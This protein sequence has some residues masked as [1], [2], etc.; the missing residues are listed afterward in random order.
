[1]REAHCALVRR[2]GLPVDASA[3]LQFHAHVEQALEE[4]KPR[5]KNAT[6][7]CDGVVVAG[8]RFDE[9]VCVFRLYARDV[10]RVLLG[11]EVGEKE[12]VALAVRSAVLGGCDAIFPHVLFSS[13]ELEM[14]DA[15]DLLRSSWPDFL[16]AAC[17]L[18]LAGGTPAAASFLEAGGDDAIAR[19][20]SVE[21]DGRTALEI[22]LYSLQFG[23]FFHRG[24]I[25]SKHAAALLG[26]WED[27]RV[28]PPGGQ[29]AARRAENVLARSASLLDAEEWKALCRR[30]ALAH[31]ARVCPA[32]ASQEDRAQSA[33]FWVEFHNSAASVLG[34]G[35][36]AAAKRRRKL[37]LFTWFF[38]GGTLYAGARM[39]L[40][41]EEED[42]LR[43]A[44]TAALE[45][46]SALRA[47]LN[48]AGKLPGGGPST[49]LETLRK[50]HVSDAKF[51]VDAVPGDTISQCVAKAAK[52]AAAS[53]TGAFLC[54]AGAPKKNLTNAAI[55]F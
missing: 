45:A 44:G 37:A 55:L 23:A 21:R 1:M 17:L 26:Q 54:G 32:W 18:A 50:V 46:E 40:R 29:E 10:A 48:A 52:E 14:A 20:A 39:L 15:Y 42:A 3:E 12:F 4:M 19:L 41:H 16:D 49:S 2:R 30:A 27:E 34:L 31:E 8:R 13:G 53:K 28:L 11:S 35:R 5:I 38:S 43:W 36:R 33:D 51:D 24:S 7:L 6:G 47:S 9:L 25:A 22:L